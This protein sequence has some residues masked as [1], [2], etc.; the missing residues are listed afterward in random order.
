MPDGEMETVLA[1]HYR[2]SAEIR[3][4]KRDMKPLPNI[5]SF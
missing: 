2:R 5:P 3:K 1:A 4:K